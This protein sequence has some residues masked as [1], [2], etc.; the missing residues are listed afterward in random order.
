MHLQI[1]PTDAPH[2]ALVVSPLKSL[3]ADQL[4]HCEH[5]GIKAVMLKPTGE[6]TSEERRGKHISISFKIT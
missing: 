3:M 1:T 4:R 5:M 2:V 6:M